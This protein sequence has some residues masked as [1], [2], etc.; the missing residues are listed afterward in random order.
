[1]PCAFCFGR[2]RPSS[3]RRGARSSAS[4]L[5]R[6]CAP[7]PERSPGASS[8]ASAIARALVQQ[9]L[10]ILA[11][12]PIASLDPRMARQVLDLLCRLAEDDG[13]ALLCTL[14]QHDLAA[15][16]FPRVL[17]MNAGRFFEGRRPSAEATA[18]PAPPQYAGQR[19][20]VGA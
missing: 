11:D 12:E 9:P 14:H 20:A 19:Q 1:M 13:V 8:S 15:Q 10:L 3:G 16:Y 4:R 7:A 6:S 18:A 5:P 17:E 2:W